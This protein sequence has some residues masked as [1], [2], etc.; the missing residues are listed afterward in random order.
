[1]K[2]YFWPL[3]LTALLIWYI[4]AVGIR[5][6]ALFT[7]AQPVLVALGVAAT[8]FVALAI[9]FIYREWQLAV[10]TDRMHRAAAAE[11]A[12]ILDD[13]PRSPGGRVKMEAAREQ[14]EQFAVAVESQPESWL[15]WYHLAWACDAVGQRRDA[16]QSLRRAASL[17]RTTPGSSMVDEGEPKG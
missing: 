11:Q 12:L 8:V 6:I 1:M 14:F 4:I 9:W 5:A 3:I 16:R 2:K 13:L 15:A 7:S 10:F 17:F